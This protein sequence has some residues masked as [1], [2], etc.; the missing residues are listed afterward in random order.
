MALTDRV[1][2]VLYDGESY[3]RAIA[4]LV[5]APEAH[6]SGALA[7]L[8]RRGLVTAQRRGR[9][10]YY[11]AA[12]RQACRSLSPR[13]VEGEMSLAEALMRDNQPV[14]GL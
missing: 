10:V 2:N 4:E 3:A 13:P 5:D 8:R 7:T 6:V 14:L 9:R 11:A 1:L 12:E